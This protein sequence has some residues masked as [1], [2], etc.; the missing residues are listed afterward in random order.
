MFVDVLVVVVDLRCYSNVVFPNMKLPGARGSS[1][2]K[3]SFH[4]AEKTSRVTSTVFPYNI[5]RKAHSSEKIIHI[6]LNFK[7]EELY[8]IYIIGINYESILM[9]DNSGMFF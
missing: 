6:Y 7:F 4:N 3:N 9:I 8:I 5:Q 1:E 2:E